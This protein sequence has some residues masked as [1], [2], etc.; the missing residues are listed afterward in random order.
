MLTRGVLVPDE[1]FVG[2]DPQTGAQNLRTSNDVRS[3]WKAGESKEVDWVAGTEALLDP[4]EVQM[5]PKQN[6]DEKQD[7]HVNHKAE[8]EYPPTSRPDRS[9]EMSDNH[10]FYEHGGHYNAQQ[11]ATD[12]YQTSRASHCGKAEETEEHG[13]QEFRYKRDA[14]SANAKGYD[15]FDQGYRGTGTRQPARDEYDGSTRESRRSRHDRQ[16]SRDLFDERT[17]WA[18]S[19][20][21]HGVSSRGR[22]SRGRSN[23]G[24]ID[25]MYYRPN[26]E[27]DDSG[28]YF[29]S[30]DSR[31]RS[32]TPREKV[33]TSHRR[34]R[35][36]LGERERALERG[37][38]HHKRSYRE[39]EHRRDGYPQSYNNDREER[40]RSTEFRSSRPVLELVRRGSRDC[41]DGKPK[42]VWRSKPEHQS[43]ILLPEEKE[44]AVAYKDE[45]RH[46]RASGVRHSEPRD[47]GVELRSYG[48]DPVKKSRKRGAKRD[49]RD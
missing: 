22:G 37:Y 11:E 40:R 49:S 29:G 34:E 13:R 35:S 31:R 18:S 1:A 16:E 24:L 2:I 9:G 15:L 44:V 39:S 17:P 21:G 14:D 26:Y 4:L 33:R 19:N 36:P 45:Y 3:E 10:G 27:G 23:R 6:P 32:R 42:P 7:D 25:D 43:V 28:K 12:P 30:H 48:Q 47:L 20:Y 41:G 46:D 38:E 8:F 5:P